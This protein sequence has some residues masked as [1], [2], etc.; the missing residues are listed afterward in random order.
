MRRTSDVDTPTAGLVAGS[1]VDGLDPGPGLGLDLDLALSDEVLAGLSADALRGRLAALR[2]LEG[3]VV[4]AQAAALRADGVDVLM[5]EHRG[6]GLSRLDAEGEELPSAVMTLPEV[7]VTMVG[8]SWDMLSERFM[9]S[10]VEDREVSRASS[11]AKCLK[12]A[13][14]LAFSAAL[15]SSRRSFSTLALSSL[16]SFSSSSLS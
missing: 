6:V 8:V 10:G 7:V 12:S 11:P 9:V 4:V 1:P 15:R 5:M 13:S 3:R 2:V 14:R 16:R